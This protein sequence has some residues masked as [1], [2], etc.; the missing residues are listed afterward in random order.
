M[1]GSDSSSRK[2]QLD[3]AEREHLEDVVEE[4]RALVEREVEYELEQQYDLSEREGGEGLSD[5]EQAVREDLVDA[6]EQENPGDKSWEWA[7]EQYLSGVGYTFVNRLAALRC[8]E[9]RGFIDQPV[10][11]IG[12]S[13][14]TPAAEQVVANRFDLGPDEAVITAY[15]QACER[16]DDEIEILFDTNSPYSVLDVDAGLFEDAVE[17]LDEIPAE[18]WRA[19]DVLG[20]VYEYYN[21]PVVESLDAKNS[22]DP[23]DVGPANQF[24]TPHWVVRMLTDNSLGKLYLESTGQEDAIPEPESLSPEQRK[25]RLVTPEDSPS[26]PELCT[27]LIPDEEAGE[28]PE[29]DHPRELRVIDPA[30]GSGH[31]LLYAFDILERIWW[32]ETDLDRAEIPAKV[33]EHNLY[34]VDIDLRSCQLSAFNL[35]LKAR[36]RAEEEDGNFEMPNVGIVCADARVAE[37]DEGAAVLDKITGEGSEL[38]EA[39]NNIIATFRQTEA[40]G[41]L[42]DVSGTLE[43]VFDSTKTQSE[44]GDFQQGDHQ[45]LNSFLKALRRAVEERTSD[46]FGEQNLRSFL[47]LLVVLT[48]EYDTALMNPPYG[49]G[50][51][52]PDAVQEYVEENYEYTTEYYINFFEVCDRLAKAD[53]RTGMLVPWS[54]MFNKSFQDFREDFVGE[55]GAFDF[56][57]EF[58]YDILD[59]ATVGTVGTVVRSEAESGQSG[60]FIRLPDVEKA[61]KEGKFLT[62]SFNTLASDVQR[63]YNR[64]LSEFDKVPGTPLSY[65]VPK[66]LR[67]LYQSET[68]LDADNAGIDGRETLGDIKQGIA[69]AD[70]S[71]FVHQFWEDNSSD[72]VPFAKGGADAW[73]LPRTKNTLLW[74]EDG[75]EVSRYPKSYPRNTQYY[76]NES[77]TYTV[78]KR[79]GRRF[80]YLPDSSVFGHKGSVLVPDRAIWNALSYTNSHLFT[81]LM[82]TQ[83]S[84]RMWEVGFV[85]KVPW[86]EELEELDEL[87]TL[88]R[89]AVGH[90]ISK[91]Q[92]DFVSPHYNGPLLLDAL[93]VDDPLGSYDHPHREL[94]EDLELD[95]PAEKASPS[96]SLRQT[97]TAAAKHLERVEKNLQICANSIDE[98]VFDC[99]GITDEQRETVLQEIALRTIE[100]PRTQ[101]EYDPDSITEP[102]DDFP[103]Q[104]KDLLLHF[105]LRAVQESDDGIIPTSSIEGKE[106]LLAHIEAEF[107]RV[108]G[109]HAEDRLAEV[110][111]ILGSQSAAEEAYPNLRTWLEEDLFDYHVKKFDRTPILWRFTTERLVSDVESQGFGCLIDYH[112]LDAGVFDR[113]QNNYLDPRKDTLRDRRRAANRRRNNDSLSTTEQSEAAQ[114]Y[115]RYDN[116]LTQIQEF[117]DAMA[118]LAQPSPR[119]FSEDNQETAAEAA[120]RVTEFRERTE[121]RLDVVD[122]LAEMEDVDLGE[123]FTGNFYEKVNE[124]REEWIDALVDLETAFEAYAAD[125]SEP[126][127]AHLYDLFNYFADD[128]LG[129]S[130]FASNGILYMTYY[131]DKLENADQTS[132]DGAGVSERER[133]ISQLASDVD[134][135]IGLGENI[136][137]SCGAISSEISDEWADRALSEITTAGYRPNHKH[138]V[139]INIT[140]L[141]DQNIVPRTV[142]DDVL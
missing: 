83:T 77:L 62:T 117:E 67:E 1:S 54:F 45:S 133:L 73:L 130:H 57:S 64:S 61:E 43:E 116:E 75:T 125:T 26:V 74:G 84:E 39:L 51:R 106:D 40:L 95:E 72:W 11:Q 104:V 50:G 88:S 2:A 136:A 22:L 91:R 59:N 13:G 138:G 52:M 21:R 119:E 137:H 8:L 41:S 58:G 140:P 142:E 17:Q 101:E 56:F 29:F 127:E 94:R 10:T 110:D 85:S 47:N 44:L 141:A 28:A 79:S 53:G 23:E 60:T 76:F 30:C 38:R 48:Q 134:E 114:E 33:L 108:W 14:M 121:Q 86:R 82:L 97:G 112:Q 24:Y 102:S 69:T 68:V 107:A 34:G 32:E 35:Y 70:D 37:I 9:V 78:A 93:G 42:L 124:Q 98:A 99:F 122:E 123:L 31:F 113:L 139:A 66:D 115:A 92:Y 109:E 80:G 96:E 20:W 4:L 15:E 87:S 12:E 16:F 46:S 129:S 132:L 5:E 131:F 25:E 49:S 118:D 65:W 55:R 36:T 105:T 126:V 7:Y 63:L 135:Y 103:E 100:N 6:V 71:R 81:Y 120:E 128:L 90:L 3:K 18:V 111:D 19:D 27:Y 89:E